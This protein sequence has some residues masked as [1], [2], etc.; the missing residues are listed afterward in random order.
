[1]PKSLSSDIYEF[2]ELKHLQ[3]VEKEKYKESGMFEWFKD[4]KLIKGTIYEMLL[5]KH[6]KIILKN[7]ILIALF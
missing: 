1:M 3:E 4:K 7:N 5:N 6:K 2:I